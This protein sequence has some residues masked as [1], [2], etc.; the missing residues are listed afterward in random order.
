MGSD[1]VFIITHRL[2][3]ISIFF[4]L[5]VLHSISDYAEIPGARYL[6]EQSIQ[7]GGHRGNI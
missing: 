7:G 1:D 3:H 5:K 2:S 4:H 6:T